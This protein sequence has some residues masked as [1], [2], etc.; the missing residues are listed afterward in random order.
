MQD[1]ALLKEEAEISDTIV[2]QLGSHNLRLGFSNQVVPFI[3]PN[4]IAYR[5][6]E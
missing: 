4:I 2:L 3:I 1:P 5:R 6:T